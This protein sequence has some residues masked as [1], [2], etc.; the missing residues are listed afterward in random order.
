MMRDDDSKTKPIS[1]TV[2][3][4]SNLDNMSDGDIE[5]PP[6]KCTFYDMTH[7]N[8]AARIRLWM[9]IKDMHHVVDTKL[10]THADLE[11][12]EYQQIN[13]LKKVPSLVTDKGL[14]LFEAQVVLQYLEDRF[15][16]F[17]PP[18]L[19]LDTPDDCALCNLIVKCH[20]LY[21][22]SPNCTQPNFTH[23]QGCLYLDPYP[24]SFT[25][26][27]RT[28]TVE[29]RAAKLKELFQQLSWLEATIQLPYMAGKQMTHADLTWYPTAIFME[30]L[31]PL[32]FDWSPIFHEEKTFP[33]LTKWF[34]TCSENKHFDL[35]RKEI[36][37]TLLEQSSRGRFAPV[38]TE[39]KEH[40]EY[41]W[42]YM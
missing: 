12:D 4:I 37:E 33:K 1:N 2:L 23:T 41:K 10:L 24:T 13:P 25:P 6:K 7:S 39:A 20:D 31:L 5:T 32:V 16:G 34:Q 19:V 22:A 38:R 8:N 28:M 35:T 14:K 18:S 9:R 3:I 36:R 40:P 30:L 26:A 15:G 11:S 21:I 42:K 17:G 27:K 29:T